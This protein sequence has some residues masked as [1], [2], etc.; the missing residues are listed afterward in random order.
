[1][2]DMIKN[3]NAQ[4]PAVDTTDKKMKGKSVSENSMNVLKKQ[5]TKEVAESPV[6][7]ENKK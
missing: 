3:T 6:E 2:K 4:Q 5:K 7:K 1:M